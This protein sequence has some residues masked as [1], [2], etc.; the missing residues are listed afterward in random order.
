MHDFEVECISVSP[1][2]R[3]VV[4]GGN[5]MRAEVWRSAWLGWCVGFSPDGQWIA[6]GNSGISRLDVGSGKPTKTF[7][8]SD[9]VMCLAFSPDGAQLAMGTMTGKVQVSDVQTGKILVGPIK[10]HASQLPVRSVVFTPDGQQIITTFQTDEITGIK[11][12]DVAMG[13]EVGDPIKP[14][15]NSVITGIAVSLDGRC[16]ASVHSSTV[17]IWDLSKR[18][19]IGDSLQIGSY[20]QR[21][22]SAAWSPNGQFVITG[23][24]NGNVQLWDAPPL[25][26]SDEVT[27]PIPAESS[28]PLPVSI[29]AG[30]QVCCCMIITLTSQS[31]SRPRANSV[32]SSILNFPAVSPPALPRPPE[33]IK[34]D[35]WEHSTNESFDSVLDLP[36]DGT[37][38]A[39]RRKRRRRRVTPVA[40]TSSPPISPPHRQVPPV[41]INPPRNL[42][43]NNRPP[44]PLERTMP[45]VPEAADVPAVRAGALRRLWMQR[46]SLPRWIRRKP[47][48]NRD[49][50]HESRSI[51]PAHFSPAPNTSTNTTEVQPHPARAASTHGELATGHVEA[52]T[53]KST[54]LSRLLPRSKRQSNTTPESVE[55]HPPPRRR[56]PSSHTRHQS[57][58]V[59]VAA[60][61]L[62]QVI[63][64]S[65]SE[66]RQHNGA[67]AGD[68]SGSSSSSE[69][70]PVDL[71]NIF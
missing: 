37:Q 30:I 44:A 35:N 70:V 32:S 48:K 1:D 14:G 59:N 10:V 21:I 40:S 68:S 4:C 19:K 31:P 28:P 60:G 55:M 49:E 41:T 25:E 11:S 61:R 71:N 39:K 8:T 16:L 20:F 34:D 52:T 53:R 56:N 9:M 6:V 45:N 15:V 51:E 69:H 36:A 7:E 33:S 24:I 13:R 23:D 47:R 22:S 43:Q 17:Y 66:R 3:T 65:D 18:R 58:V 67:G 26:E 46:R 38:P 2:E 42:L 12:W 5:G 63:S 64:E 62:D 57:G 29:V 54:I 27:L 50:S